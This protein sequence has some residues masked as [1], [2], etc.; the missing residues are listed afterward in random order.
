M[1]LRHD[2]LRELDAVGQMQDRARVACAQSAVGDHLANDLGQLQEAQQV[3]DVRAALADVVAE[4]LLG[5]GELAETP[6]EPDYFPLDEEYDVNPMDSYALSKVINE[7][8]ARA[9]TQR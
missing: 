3:R 5:V 9:F 4:S 7:Q 2:L 1:A 6:R 8:T